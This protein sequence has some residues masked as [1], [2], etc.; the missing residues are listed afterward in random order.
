MSDARQ[1][2]LGRDEAVAEQDEIDLEL[3]S[4]VEIRT[5][6]LILAS[7]LR[8]LSLEDCTNGDGSDAIAEAFDEREWLREQKLSG[9]LTADEAAL[10]DSPPGSVAREAISEASWQGEALLV[11][12]WA[13]GAHDM[14][15]L[16][17]VF[18]PRPLL[19]AV[20]SPWD[21]TKEWL[22]DP[23]IIA[24]SEAA[25]EREVAEIWYWRL[26]T[27]ALR[28]TAS[29]ADRQ[30]Y[31]EAIRD[32]AAEALTAGFLPALRDGDFSMDG[33]SIKD[34]SGDDIDVLIAVTG[35]RLRAL[36]WLCGFGKS[37]DEIPLDI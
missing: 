2:H 25:R 28:R 35:Q 17:T 14:A 5:R 31:E 16:G 21:G 18:D 9:G 22:G 10:L 26:T 11:L 29:A 4:P 13:I 24:E 6:I 7:I 27:E 3:R 34:L 33:S 12:G 20:P 1:S 30:D 23:A 32:V 15:P 19:D 37:W 36:N 8:R